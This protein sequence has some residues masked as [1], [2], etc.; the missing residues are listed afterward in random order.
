[1][2]LQN[3]ADTALS[4]LKDTFKIGSKSIVGIDI[5]LSSVKIAEMKKISNGRY[6]LIR[7]GSAMLPEGAIVEDEIQREDDILMALGVASKKAKI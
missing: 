2:D 3:I 5:G 6:K 7:Y 4:A 1:M